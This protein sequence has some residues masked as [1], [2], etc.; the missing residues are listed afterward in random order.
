MSRMFKYN[1]AEFPVDF[2]DADFF[3][4]YW[5]SCEQLG[6]K[7]KEL[8]NSKNERGFMRKYCDMFYGFFDH[9]F[10]EGA[11]EKIYQGRY[12]VSECEKV[13]LQFIEFCGKEVRR[14]NE[15][16]VAFATASR[17]ISQ[18]GTNREQRRKAAKKNRRRK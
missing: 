8:Q 17:P 9:L 10:G 6:T 2:D 13:Y 1:E 4:K 14:F 11:G 7:E 15:G 3:E 18:Q 5:D 16:R 12:N